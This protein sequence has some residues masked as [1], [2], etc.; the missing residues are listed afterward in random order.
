MVT[1]VRVHQGVVLYSP[2]PLTAV[3]FCKVQSVRFRLP[4]LKITPPLESPEIPLTF[5]PWN[6]I[7]VPVTSPP[8]HKALPADPDLTR[9]VM[10]PEGPARVSKHPSRT[11]RGVPAAS[12]TTPALEVWMRMS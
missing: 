7:L 9:T 4:W 10:P 11:L 1:W 3:P 8:F 12:I 5:P 6:V 2:P